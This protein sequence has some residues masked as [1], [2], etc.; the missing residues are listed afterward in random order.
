MLSTPLGGQEEN[1]SWLAR[2]FLTNLIRNF[3]KGR[4]CKES[5]ILIDVYIYI[6]LILFIYLAPPVEGMRQT[7]LERKGWR[8]ARRK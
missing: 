1:G 6:I 8:E 2:C 5:T 3:G 7:N 4:V